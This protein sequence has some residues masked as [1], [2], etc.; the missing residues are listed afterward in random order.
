MSATLR[1]VLD[2]SFE[3]RSHQRIKPMDE[4]NHLQREERFKMKR[5]E[6]KGREGKGREGKRGS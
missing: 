1:Y 3:F 5:K 6:G 2:H 4:Q